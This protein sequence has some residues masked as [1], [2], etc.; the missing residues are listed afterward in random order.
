M[1]RDDI[2]SILCKLKYSSD[3]FPTMVTSFLYEFGDRKYEIKFERDAGRVVKFQ[4]NDIGMSKEKVKEME[5]EHES[6]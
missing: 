4:I 6:N 1:R 3:E 2:I 5:V